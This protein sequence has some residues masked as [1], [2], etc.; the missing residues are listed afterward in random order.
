MT[1]R[2]PHKLDKGHLHS[3]HKKSLRC[4]A[5]ASSEF[6][7]LPFQQS[8]QIELEEDDFQVHPIQEKTDEEDSFGMELDPELL[9]YSM[10]P[11]EV[12]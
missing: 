4:E 12:L 2:S 8:N 3:I 5:T 6:Y 9:S 7:R 1:G 11:N 10:Y